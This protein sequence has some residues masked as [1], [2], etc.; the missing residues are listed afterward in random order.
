MKTYNIKQDFPTKILAKDRLE[1]ILKY[2][3]E[4]IIKIIHGY[5][6][7]GVGGDIKDMIRELLELKLHQKKIKAYI[8]GEAFGHLLGYDYVIKTYRKLLS[9]D[10]LYQRPNE[11][12][13]YIII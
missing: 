2:E 9:Q 8:P 3:K 11:G 4:A 1:I 13:T 7:S 12:I 5:G 6:S 10:P